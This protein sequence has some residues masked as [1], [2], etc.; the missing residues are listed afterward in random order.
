M[1]DVKNLFEQ[2]EKDCI[3]HERNSDRNKSLSIKEYLNEIKPF[4]KYIKNNLKKSDTW[5]FI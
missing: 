2:E 5:K 4:L 3:E 1:R